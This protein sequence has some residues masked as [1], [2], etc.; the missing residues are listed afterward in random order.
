MDVIA[1]PKHPIR[2]YR[3]ERGLSQAE[4]GDLI[5][6]SWITV[7]RWETGQM[8]HKRDWTLL[9]EKLGIEP[10]ELVKFYAPEQVRQ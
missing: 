10:V 8:P 4:L 3:D 2:K 9:R 6:R 5:G 7:H 1:E